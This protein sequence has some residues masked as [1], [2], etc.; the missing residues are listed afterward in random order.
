MFSQTL[1]Y[2]LRACLE[3]ARRS[4][5]GPV[6]VDDISEALNVPRNYLS[7]V[8][9][10]LGREGLLTSTRGPLGG[11]ELATSPDEIPLADIAR[12]FQPELLNEE[13]RCVLGRMRCDD[14]DPCAAHW[15]WKEVA[16]KLQVF[17]RQTTLA[18]LAT[19]RQ[20]TPTEVGP[21]TAEA[22]EKG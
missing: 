5:E 3:L 7:K 22:P 16:A 14:R 1:E 19:S 10:T 18:D 2:A 6:R 15:R 21:P 11:F 8:L 4:D 12:H 13:G 20:E 17:F 9:H